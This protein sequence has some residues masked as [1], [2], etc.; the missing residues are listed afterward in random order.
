VGTARRRAFAHPTLYCATTRRDA[1]AISNLP[2]PGICGV[3]AFPVDAKVVGVLAR[4]QCMAYPGE[5]F[6]RLV[7]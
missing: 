4:Q 3:K 6:A 5:I 7:P 1:G 2:Q